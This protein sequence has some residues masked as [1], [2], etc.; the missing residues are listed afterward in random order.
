MTTKRLQKRE[1]E[2]QV[3]KLMGDRGKDF[4]TIAKVHGLTDNEILYLAETGKA[5]KYMHKK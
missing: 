1:F 3:R 5:Y 4:I 2:T